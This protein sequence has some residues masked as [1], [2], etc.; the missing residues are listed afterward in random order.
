MEKIDKISLLLNNID[1]NINQLRYKKK[2]EVLKINTHNEKVEENNKYIVIYSI[3]EIFT[4]IIV[5]ISQSYYI[6]SL[7]K[8]I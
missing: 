5:F 1:N 3:I 2:I 4:M 7:V 6:S 8:K